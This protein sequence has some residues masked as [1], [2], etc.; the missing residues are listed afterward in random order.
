MY[1]WTKDSNGTEGTLAMEDKQTVAGRTLDALY[2][3]T[4]LSEQSPLVRFVRRALGER[5]SS[6]S[7]V[8]GERERR[9]ARRSQRVGSELRNRALTLSVSA[10]SAVVMSGGCGMFGTGTPAFMMDNEQP[11]EEFIYDNFSKITSTESRETQLRD[12]V[13]FPAR[14]TELNTSYLKKPEADLRTF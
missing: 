8:P 3:R 1:R 12:G 11:I 10:V 7:A 5:G 13:L 14:Y 4:T 9:F 6:A 2:G